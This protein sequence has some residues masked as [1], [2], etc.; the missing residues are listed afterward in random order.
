[1]KTSSFIGY[2]SSVLI[3]LLLLDAVSAPAAHGQ[4]TFAMPPTFAGL[5][6]GFVADNGYGKPDI[7]S[8]TVP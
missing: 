2:I 1:M 5:T 4:V 8:W 3:V 7:L 6:P